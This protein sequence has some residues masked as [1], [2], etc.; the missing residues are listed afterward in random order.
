MMED[1][2]VE[3]QKEMKTLPGLF[4]GYFILRIL[5]SGQLDLKTGHSLL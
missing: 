3:F 5:D 1:W 2:L 4:M